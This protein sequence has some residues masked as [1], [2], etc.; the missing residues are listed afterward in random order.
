MHKTNDL[1]PICKTQLNPENVSLRE[2]SD[3]TV[4]LDQ[5]GRT[6]C[7]KCAE[8]LENTEWD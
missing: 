8:W 4:K 7:K 2:C 1:C 5:A 6:I 3:K